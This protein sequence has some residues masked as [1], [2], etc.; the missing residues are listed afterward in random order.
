MT[1][2]V[3][4]EPARL[5]GSSVMRLQTDDRL[6][7][8]VRAGNDRAFEAIVDRYR[9]P[10]LRY[11]SRL[12]PPAR[13]E[14]AVQQAFLNAFAGLRRGDERIDLRPWLYRI[15]HNASLNALRENGWTHERIEAAGARPGGE[16]AHEA[17]ERRAS[18]RTVLAAVQDL[19][20][21]QRDAMILRELEGRTYEQIATELDASGGAVRQLLNRARHTLRSAATA[22]TPAGILARF[23]WTQ[24]GPVVERMSEAAS[25][26]GLRSGAARI[27][28][29]LVAS[30]AV[31]AGLSEGP[32]HLPRL[33]TGPRP[34]AKA[35]A[36]EARAPAVVPGVVS[37]ASS[38][39]PSVSVRP[40]R[41][42]R[43]ATRV[44]LSGPLV[45]R[46]TRRAPGP[47]LRPRAVPAIPGVS[48]P[49]APAPAPRAAPTAAPTPA[50][51][52]QSDR[53]GGHPERHGNDDHGPQVRTARRQERGEGQPG[54]DEGRGSGGDGRRGG[55]GGGEAART[56]GD[57]GSHGDGGDGGQGGGGDAGARGQS[58]GRAGGD[59]S[60]PAAVPATDLHTA[61]RDTAS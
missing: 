46:G 16:S 49:A 60:G 22:L 28:G 9:R 58:Q 27:G 20:E 38:A 29:A 39:P 50:P 25:Q 35:A 54:G 61:V 15:A 45:R 26:D 10:L 33:D 57:E 36:P 1:P 6:V 2:R 8:L 56:Q 47:S 11:C 48:T 23:P 31:A 51:A 5:A 4:I 21:R 7:D 24:G 32:Q 41:T 55:D 14:D 34:A 37:L 44:V 40:S 30:V 59:S 12:L 52:P 19:P 53:R 3:L 13:A 17:A 43:S 42:D 18:L